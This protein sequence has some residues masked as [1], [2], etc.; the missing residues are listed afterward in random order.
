MFLTVDNIDVSSYADDTTPY[1]CK[2]N[3]K[4]SMNELE[5]VTNKLFNWFSQNHFKANASKC[6]SYEKKTISIENSNIRKQQL[7]NFAGYKNWQ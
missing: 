6:H 4:Q 1:V 2:Q 5:N 7:W 3:Y